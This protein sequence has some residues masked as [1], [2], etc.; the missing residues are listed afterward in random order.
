MSNYEKITTS[1]N[2]TN[3]SPSTRGLIGRTRGA[4]EKRKAEEELSQN[5]NTKKARSR[6]ATF[7]PLEKELELRK[8]A[9]RTAINRS[10]RGLKVTIE[11]ETAS[12]VDK[13]RM[14]EV[15]KDEIIV[16]R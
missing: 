7:T 14:I 8:N 3:N 4:Q 9:D 6:T 15:K 11:Y 10:I 12:E 13:K 5:P 1:E 16:K 2:L